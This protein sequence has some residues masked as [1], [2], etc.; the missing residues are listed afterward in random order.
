MA[1]PTPIDK[2]TEYRRL[3]ASCL[4]VAERMSL[5]DDRLRMMEMAQHWLDLA[6][7]AEERQSDQ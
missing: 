2:A 7:R 6:R 5:A 1:G 3:A 4:Q